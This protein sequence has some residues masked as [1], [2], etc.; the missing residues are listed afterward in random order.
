MRDLG[1][2][3]GEYVRGQVSQAYGDRW[4]QVGD[5]L[6][7]RC[8]EKRAGTG[9]GTG[10]APRTPLPNRC[11]SSLFGAP[12]GATQATLATPATPKEP[13]MSDL[14]GHASDTTEYRRRMKSWHGLKHTT[15]RACPITVINGRRCHWGGDCLCQRHPISVLDHPRSWTDR[16][17]NRV[18]T[19]EPYSVWGEEL[20]RLIADCERE[21]LRLTIEPASGY[22]PAATVLIIIR[23]KADE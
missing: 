18:Y 12:A 7:D 8:S 4:G 19:A 16:D 14:P 13:T 1:T 10:F 17:G 6:G 2:G 15:R 23:A 21:G 5:S 22:A 11:S 9:L 20:G 3:G